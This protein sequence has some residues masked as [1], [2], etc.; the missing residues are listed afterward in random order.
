MSKDQF[1]SLLQKI[2]DAHSHNKCNMNTKSFAQCISRYGGERDHNKVQE[3]ITNITIYK[4]VENISDD[5][6]LK[7]LPILLTGV[8]DTW[9]DRVKN[10][11]KMESRF[12]SLKIGVCPKTLAS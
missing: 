9:W 3:F 8:T 11:I 7:G 10:D 6:A 2:R 5:D 4:K 1:S 12:G